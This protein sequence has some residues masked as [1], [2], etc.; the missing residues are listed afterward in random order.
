[1]NTS[2]TTFRTTLHRLV[3]TAVG[4]SAIAVGALAM[5]APANAATS[6]QPTCEQHPELY[7]TGA[8]LGVYSTQKRGFDRDQIC[9]VYDASHKLLGT[10]TA[11]DYGYYRLI[12]PVTPQ[13]V[14][15]PV[16]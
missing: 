15:S 9:K 4:A 11:T 7:A 12:Q 6:I 16:R 5:S 8:V 10:Y 1:M 3:A 14:L 2:H 13:P